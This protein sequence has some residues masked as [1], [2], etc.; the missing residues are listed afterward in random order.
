MSQEQ[1]LREFDALACAAFR[2]TGLA[3]SASFDS[4]DAVP[5]PCTVLVDL[6]L[7]RV[8]IIASV[9]SGRALISLFRAEVKP[10]RGAVVTIDGTG[11]RWVLEKPFD[12]D[13]SRERWEATCG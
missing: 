9:S 8:G 2:G 10:R 12:A 3:D 7:A 4:G 6:D 5:V 13:E 1:F 11:A